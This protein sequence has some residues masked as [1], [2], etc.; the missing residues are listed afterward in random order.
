MRNLS[1]LFLRSLSMLSQLIII[2]LQT[3]MLCR[4]FQRTLALAIASNTWRLSGLYNTF[5]TILPKRLCNL[6]EASTTPS[7]IQWL[8]IPIT[9]TVLLDRACLQPLHLQ[10]LDVPNSIGVLLDRAVG[11]KDAASCGAHDGHLCPSV[12]VQ[13]SLVDLLLSLHPQR[14]NSIHISCFTFV[15]RKIGV[16]KNIGLLR[17][18]HGRGHGEN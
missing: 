6:L 8:G 15:S 5:S 16:L 3:F 18:G 4:S 9:I 7:T 14:T 2:L 17:K 1:L 11:R 12:L 13:V 10:G